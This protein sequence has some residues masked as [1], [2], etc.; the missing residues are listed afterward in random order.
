MASVELDNSFD[1]NASIAS[2]I[3]CT[4]SN[5][6]LYN[7]CVAAHCAVRHSVA[8]MARSDMPAKPSLRATAGPTTKGPMPTANSDNF[9]AA[10]LVAK[11]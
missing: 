8:L 1:A 4:D 7:P 2:S 6:S 10:C 3:S 5:M 9:T 11:Q